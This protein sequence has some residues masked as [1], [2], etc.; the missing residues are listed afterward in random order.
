MASYCTE[1]L[2]NQKALQKPTARVFFLYRS[3]LF[4]I[5]NFLDSYYEGTESVAHLWSWRLRL[6]G[7]REGGVGGV[8]SHTVQA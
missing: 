1:R 4:L 7:S 5:L 3:G 8:N 6:S 2:E